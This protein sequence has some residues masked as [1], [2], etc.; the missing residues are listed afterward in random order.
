MSIVENKAP[1]FTLKN[2]QKEDV[3]LSN[4]KGKPVVLAFY[5]GAFTGVCDTEMCKLKEDMEVFNEFNATVLGIIVDSPWANNAFSEKYNLNF[6]LL[7]DL[8]RSVT[9]AYDLLFEGL[10]GIEGYTCSNRG[11][12]IIDSEGIIQY[13]WVAEPNPGV[14]PNYDEIKNFIKAL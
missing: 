8:D 12:V 6:D 11:I 1:E 13:R 7:S 2:T 3:S 9:K 4:F 14:E 10:G 5:P